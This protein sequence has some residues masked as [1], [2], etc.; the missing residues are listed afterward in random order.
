MRQ[1]RKT[2]VDVARQQQVSALGLTQHFGFERGLILLLAGETYL[3]TYT[4]VAQDLAHRLCIEPSWVSS[5]ERKGK[6][7]ILQTLQRT[8]R[9]R[10]AGNALLVC[11]YHL[12]FSLNCLTQLVDTAFKQQRLK[13]WQ[14]ILTPKTVLPTLFIIGI[15]FAPIGGL[16]IWGS[17]LVSE[18]SFDYTDCEN[19]TPSTANDSLTFTDFPSNKFSYR[20]RAADSKVAAPKSPRFAFLDNTNNSTVTD[21]SAKKQCVVEFDLPADLEASVLFYY[22]L[23]NFF[24]NHRRYVKSLNSNQLKG[25][26][27]NTN[28]LDK[29]DCKPLATLG[30]KAIYPCGLI[31]NSLFNG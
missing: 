10:A 30:G 6:T 8:R 12:A 7:R 19:L 2:L 9:R 13:A 25:K 27:V 5:T 1:V 23:T 22:K 29:S 3:L 26:F 16:L 15:I 14:P 31:A 24:Q 20:L 17:S 4:E 21:V 28:T 11:R 18:L